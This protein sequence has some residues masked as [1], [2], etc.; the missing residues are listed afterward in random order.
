MAPLDI[1]LAS[2]IVVADELDLSTF[3]GK[4]QMEINKIIL[5]KLASK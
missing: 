2:S 1:K 3:S 4:C 5:N